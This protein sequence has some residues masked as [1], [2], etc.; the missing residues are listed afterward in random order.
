MI[1]LQDLNEFISCISLCNT[2]DKVSDIETQLEKFNAELSSM[3]DRAQDQLLSRTL[4]TL[5][6]RVSDAITECRKE[7]DYMNR[8]IA[9]RKEY[10]SYA[11]QAKSQYNVG[12]V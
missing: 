2:P 10:G 9:E 1:D 6:D 3:C 11:D 4:N 12:R 7:I 5:Y 8:T